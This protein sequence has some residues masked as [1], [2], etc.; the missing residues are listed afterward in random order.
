MLKDAGLMEERDY[1]TYIDLFGN[2]A[3]FMYDKTLHVSNNLQEKAKLD[4]LLGCL[5]RGELREDRSEVSP[6]P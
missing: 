4:H 6:L 1:K 5:S 2:M 3:N